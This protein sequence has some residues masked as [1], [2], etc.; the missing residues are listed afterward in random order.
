MLR[1][2]QVVLPALLSL[3][4]PLSRVERKE[5]NRNKGTIHGG[6]GLFFYIQNTSLKREKMIETERQTETGQRRYAKRMIEHYQ[7][8]NVL[9]NDWK[10]LKQ[11]IEGLLH[12]NLIDEYIDQDDTQLWEL[13][14]LESRMLSE[15]EY[16]E[17]HREWLETQEERDDEAVNL[18]DWEPCLLVVDY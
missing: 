4:Y 1:S 12:D 13:R 10:L 15:K 18:R 2:T 17:L 16:R 8:N 14:E 3:L 9:P 5:D 7:S 11:M 6:S